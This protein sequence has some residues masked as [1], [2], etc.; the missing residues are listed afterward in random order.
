M[1]YITTAERGMLVTAIAAL[2]ASLRG[3]DGEKNPGALNYAVTKLV[4]YWLGDAPRYADFNAAIGAL[5]C[6][7][8]ELYR[9]AVS[10]YEDRKIA[11]NGDVYHEQAHTA[12]W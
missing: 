9:R 12:A 4:L 2:A 1:P 11:E 6:V 5:E 8:L 3:L 10:P 7:K